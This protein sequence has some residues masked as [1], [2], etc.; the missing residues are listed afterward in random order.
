MMVS[1]GADLLVLNREYVFELVFMSVFG[2]I[3]PEGSTLTRE[4]VG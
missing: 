4:K 2:V 1:S 3:V